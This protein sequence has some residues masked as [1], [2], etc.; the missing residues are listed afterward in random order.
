[1]TV[2]TLSSGWSFK[3]RD[4]SEWLPV[5]TVP[6][7]VQ[8]DLIA[9]NKS[10]TPLKGNAQILMGLLAG[11]MIHILGSKSWMLAGPMKSRG[12]IGLCSKDQMLRRVLR[13][14]WCLMVWTLL[15]K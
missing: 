1:M 12:F 9:N 2:Q 15:R 7:V 3:D 4:S 6:S 11:S 5:P 14:L 8:Q 10:A 13:F